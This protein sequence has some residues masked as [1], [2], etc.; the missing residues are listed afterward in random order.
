[1]QGLTTPLGRFGA[2]PDAVAWATLGAGVA[3]ALLALRP[4]PAA[5][6]LL[7][8]PRAVLWGL[9]LTSFV[10]SAGYVEFYLRGGPRIIDA[11]SY[12]LEA[13]SFAAGHFDFAVPSVEASFSGR[14][15]L[16]TAPLRQAVI[17]PPGYPL[18]L[19]AFQAS[20][21]PMWLGPVLAALL[22][23]LTF[24]CA[25]R[26]FP[27]DRRVACWAA[28]LSTLS[29]TL[30]YHTADTMSHG[31]CAVLWL[32]AVYFALRAW[33]SSSGRSSTSWMLGAGL[34]L[35]WLLATRP[36]TAIAAA[37]S[38]LLLRRTTATAGVAAR[39]P[40]WIAAGALPGVGLW[41]WHQAATSGS[42]FGSSQL[43]YYALADGPPGCF[44]YGLGARGCVFEHGDFIQSQ[45]P[46]GFG[47][48]QMLATTGRRLKAHLT[49]AANLEC[50]A[51]AVPWLVYRGRRSS[52]TH[53][54]AGSLLLQVLL[55]APFYFDG[56]YPGGGARFYVDA[57]PFEHLLLASA[58]ANWRFRRWVPSLGLIGFALHAAYDHHALMKREGGQPMFPPSAEVRRH[59]GGDDR[60]QVIF[61]DTDHGFNLG[62]DPGAFR[63]WSAGQ[64]HQL[65]VARRSY[66]SREALLL[67]ALDARGWFYDFDPHGNSPP[68]WSALSPPPRPREIRLEAE[69]DWPPRAVS[70]GWVHPDWPPGACV[71]QRRGLR[72]RADPRHSERMTLE[73]RLATTVKLELV[74]SKPGRYRLTTRWARMRDGDP[75]T[76]ELRVADDE[77]HTPLAFEAG[78]CVEVALPEV[79]L[80]PREGPGRL[81]RSTLQVS[82]TQTDF[83]LDVVTLEAL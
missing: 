10:L 26:L 71:S 52:V 50:F 55:Y 57:L 56:N 47:F 29:A 31:L 38:L 77:V 14:F 9:A 78:Q 39:W 36:F 33:A 20:S 4:R 74:A 13:R 75:G 32:G 30:R 3:L 34:C 41:L 45:M 70:G 59:V 53:F 81:P 35:G 5:E 1:M 46:N 16:P 61:V 76:V 72:F 60:A 24:A 69:S 12:W 28:L 54:L 79:R 42:L 73:G 18:A 15:L 80:E 64:R 23:T 37:F 17:F 8:R 11:T 19:A 65:I 27:S 22:T 83:V 6:F 21:A 82:V 43:A 44:G 51:L 67:E 66:D 48:V 25:A 58:I 40:L 49:D 2:P 7:R 63:A 68:T 62:F